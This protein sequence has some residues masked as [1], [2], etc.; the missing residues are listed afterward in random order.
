MHDEVLQCNL[1]RVQ[2]GGTSIYFFSRFMWHDRL[3]TSELSCTRLVFLEC[4]HWSY[5][6]WFQSSSMFNLHRLRRLDNSFTV[7]LKGQVIWRHASLVL[8]TCLVPLLYS[9]C[10][11]ISFFFLS[12][13]LNFSPILHTVIFGCPMGYLLFVCKF[14]V[15]LVYDFIIKWRNSCEIYDHPALPVL[16]WLAD[17]IY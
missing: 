14:S 2:K 6:Q 16:C 15:P 13:G 4:Y 5:F 12:Q 10:D 3:Y 9:L 11:F 7:L 1:I 17:W 8:R